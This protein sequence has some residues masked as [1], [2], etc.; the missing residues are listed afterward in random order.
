[1]DEQLEWT[2][3]KS[4]YALKNEK[5]LTKII[6]DRIEE[7]TIMSKHAIFLHDQNSNKIVFNT[8]IFNDEEI[9][10][11]VEKK[12]KLN[13]TYIHKRMVKINQFSIKYLTTYFL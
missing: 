9:T 13:K 10:N 11:Y 8:N 5:R 6:G 7:S 4:V 3:V 2:E 12:F 1:M